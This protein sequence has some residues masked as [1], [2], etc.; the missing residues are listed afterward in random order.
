MMT[1][2]E[3]GPKKKKTKK[4]KNQFYFLVVHGRAGDEHLLG[5]ENADKLAVRKNHGP[6]SIE[7]VNANP[8]SRPKTGEPGASAT[9][10]TVRKPNPRTEICKASSKTRAPTYRTGIGRQIGGRRSTRRSET[11][12]TESCFLKKTE[13]F[14]AARNWTASGVVTGD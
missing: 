1:N 13:R 4:K 7:V 9:R 6:I 8:N 14:W 10:E 5:K 12:R 3:Q 11:V 2:K